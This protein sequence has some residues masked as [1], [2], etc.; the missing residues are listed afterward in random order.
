M[1][2]SILTFLSVM[3][4]AA[5]VVSQPSTVTL[6]WDYPTNTVQSDVTFT[7]YSAPSLAGPFMQ[8]AKVA[9][10]T[11]VVSGTNYVNTFNVTNIT[12]TPVFFQASVSSAF[13]A[14]ATNSNI[15]EVPLWPTVFPLT[16]VAP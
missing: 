4:A 6:T 14:N 13:W 16:V 9:A 8:V 5:S 2:K 7:V 15:F 10:Q 1:K 11:N 12:N 3:L